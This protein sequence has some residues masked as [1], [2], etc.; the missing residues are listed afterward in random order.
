MQPGPPNHLWA[1][2]HL[3]RKNDSCVWIFKSEEYTIVFEPLYVLGFVKA[4]NIY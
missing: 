4:A 1:E 3:P 2:S